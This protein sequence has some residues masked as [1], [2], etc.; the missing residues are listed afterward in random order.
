MALTVVGAITELAEAKSFSDK[1]RIS[2]VAEIWN[3]VEKNDTNGKTTI[4]KG[5]EL[6]ESI[7]RFK[8]HKKEKYRHEISGKISILLQFINSYKPTPN[9]SL[10]CLKPA[11]NT[12]KLNY[13]NKHPM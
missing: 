8:P 13:S 1:I 11:E 2:L 4:I 6:K 10:S 9:S 3:A 5:Q 7:P 12:L